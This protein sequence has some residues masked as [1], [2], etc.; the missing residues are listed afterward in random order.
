MPGVAT[1]PGPDALDAFLAGTRVLVCLLPLTH[2]TRGLAER[3]VVREA[4][5]GGAYLINAS[6]GALVVE[7]DLLEALDAGQLAGAALDVHATRAAPAG[8]SAVAAR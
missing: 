2:D 8:E 7:P 6:R 3:F 5:A 4:S 1:F